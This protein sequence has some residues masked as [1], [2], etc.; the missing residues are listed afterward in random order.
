MQIPPAIPFVH[1]SDFTEYLDRLGLFHMDLGLERIASALSQLGL[2]ENAPLTVQVV[3]TNGK[4]STVTFLER[5]FFEHGQTTGLYTSPHFVDVRERIAINGK[6]LDKNVWIDAVNAVL[7]A[8]SSREADRLTYFELLTVMAAW[9]FRKSN[10]SVQIYEAGLGGTHDATTALPRHIL[11]VTPIG[12]DHTAV[13]GDTLE[14][15]ASDKAGAISAGMTLVTGMQENSVSVTLSQTAYGNDAD[16]VFAQTILDQWEAQGFPV[17]EILTTTPYRLPGAFQTGNAGLALATFF[18]SCESIGVTPQPDAVRRAL[19]HAFLP[20]RMQFL[21]TNPQLLL[22]GAH[23]PPA[24]QVLHQELQNRGLRPEAIIYTALKDKDITACAEFVRKLS[25]GP[26]FVPGLPGNERS[27]D[28]EELAHFI[29]PRAQ[30]YPDP[31]SALQAAQDTT[32]SLVLVCGSLYLV[33]AI[34][35]HAGWQPDSL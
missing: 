24:L 16:I 3:G 33:G 1:F 20:G 21:G 18:L 15:I 28:P 27:Y 5:L 35:Q 32:Q 30:A 7:A 13:L 25:D 9:L 23:N 4:G 6:V 12:L 26:I 2:H 14:A 17:N 11:A 10:V 31:V 29:G 22:D 8:S 19:S 34:L